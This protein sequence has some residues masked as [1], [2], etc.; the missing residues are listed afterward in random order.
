MS[1]ELGVNNLTEMFSKIV[2]EVEEEEFQLRREKIRYAVSENG[3]PEVKV[4][5]G[6][7]PLNYDLWKG[8][9][10]PAV[11]GLYPVD[12]QEIWEFYANRT[13]RTVDE[14]GRQTIFKISRRFDSAK[15]DFKRAVIISVMLPFSNNIIGDYAEVILKKG[16]GSSHMFM[17]MYEDINHI[18]DRATSRVAVDL[19]NNDNDVVSLDNDTVKSVSTEAVPATHQGDA[20]G[21]S[22][23]GNYPQKSIAVLMG[24]GQFGV[25]RFIFRDEFVNGEVKR[26]VGPIRSIIVFDKRDVIKDGAEGVI[27]PTD[28]WRNFLFGLYDFTNVDSQINSYRFCTYVPY[29][30]EGCGECIK[31]CPSG[32][33]PNSVPLSNGKYAEHVQRQEHRFWDKKLQ[34]DFSRC[35][36]RR[37]QMTTL[38]PEWSCAR[39]LS[40]C[41]AFGRKREYSAENFYR[42][43]HELATANL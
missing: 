28:Q 29:N 26:F 8:L 9:R 36:E 33:Q 23:G 43:M 32:A 2:T 19:I 18:I 41:A 42:K 20:H 39:C 25:G 1:E 21:P 24:L 3:K 40:V 5:V 31:C 22:K 34:F 30:D 17:R 11:V 13:R 15:R 16:K 38:F 27:Y 7:V 10:N 6:N 4:A 35:C 14:Y 37:G 12:L